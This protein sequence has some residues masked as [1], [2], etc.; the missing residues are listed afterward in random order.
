MR[1]ESK[2]FAIVLILFICFLSFPFW[3]NLGKASKIVKP[4]LSKKAK[5]EKFCVEETEYMKS[6]HMKLLNEWRDMVVR[7]G[8]RV[9]IGLNDRQ[10]DIS[11]QNTCLNCHNN[12]GEF[13]DKCHNYVGIKPYCWSCHIEPKEEN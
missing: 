9:Y 12:K 13:C 8:R 11:F 6:Y 5:K 1:N 4:E 7:K 10:Y 3:Y 2:I